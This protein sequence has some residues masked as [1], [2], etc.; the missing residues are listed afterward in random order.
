MSLIPMRV[1]YGVVRAPSIEAVQFGLV[2]RGLRRG[3]EELADCYDDVTFIVLRGLTSAW[4]LPRTDA[5]GRH[6]YCTRRL[7]VRCPGDR[8]AVSLFPKVYR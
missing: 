2:A 4:A 3:F 1:M 6:A 5:R 7:G 8:R